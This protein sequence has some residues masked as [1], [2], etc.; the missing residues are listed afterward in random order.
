MNL[1]DIVG[2]Y[3]KLGYAGSRLKK[4]LEKDKNY[5]DLLKRRVKQLSNAGISK[6]EQKKYVLFTNK[7]VEILKI[8]NMLE[9]KTNDEDKYIIRLIKTQLAEDWRTPVLKELKKLQ[10][11]YGM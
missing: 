3:I 7:D 2:F 1:D 9:K 8:C 4:I 5:Q 10:K 6:P 11:K